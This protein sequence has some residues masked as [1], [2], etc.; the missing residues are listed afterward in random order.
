MLIIGV[1]S[2][3]TIPAVINEFQ[4]QHYLTA[5]KKAYSILQQA[6]NNIYVDYG[7]NSV[8]LCGG[9]DSYCLGDIYKE[10]LK[11]LSTEKYVPNTNPEKCMTVLF[12][13][14][15]KHYCV[16]TADGLMY[17]FDMESSSATSHTA[18][19]IVD[20]NGTKKPNIYGKDIYMFAI[21][22]NKIVP[23][24]ND[25]FSCKNGKGESY[26]N[27]NCAYEYLTKNSAK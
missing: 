1:V 12:N 13:L 20:I 11:P 22:N 16:V 18:F 26:S 5:L 21:K 6:E 15:E 14:S 24:Y 10:Y 17:N 8:Y 9:N 23:Y 4:H 25:S 19:I 3:I 27:F 7:V 2:A